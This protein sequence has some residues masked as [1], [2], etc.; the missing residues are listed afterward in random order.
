[1]AVIFV[2]S[3]VGQ[4]LARTNRCYKMD[5]VRPNSYDQVDFEPYDLHGLEHYLAEK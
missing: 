5:V 2:I 1:M 3:L 4:N